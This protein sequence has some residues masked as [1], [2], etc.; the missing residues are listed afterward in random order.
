M[1]GVALTVFPET[2]GA[3]LVGL[4]KRVRNDAF[5]TPP[6]IARERKFVRFPVVQDEVLE[7]GGNAAMRVEFLDRTVLTLGPDANLVIDT[8][9]YDVNSQKGTSVFNLAVGTFHFISGRMN[10]D[11]VRIV[12]PTAQI[13]IRGSDA[14]IIVE[15]D[16]GTTV[17]VISGQFAVYNRDESDRTVVGPAQAV[18]VSAVG[19]IGV[20]EQ[21]ITEPPEDLGFTTGGGS[22][23]GGTEEDDPRHVDYDPNH[24]IGGG[25]G[26]QGDE[27][28]PEDHP[29]DDDDDHHDDDDDGHPDDDD[30]HGDGGDGH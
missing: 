12:T 16:G 21:G 22:T 19:T 3:D 20:V 8:F 30:G 14:I 18:S 11:G 5:G 29:D 10:E 15:P 26:G 9:V 13:G 27:D 23:G 1:I 24:G 17:N 2:A 25:A 4:V 7:T 28:H 6:G